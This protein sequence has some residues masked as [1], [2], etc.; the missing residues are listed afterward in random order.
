MKS[1][2]SP[3]GLSFEDGLE[4][5]QVVLIEVC[6]RNE[7][8]NSNSEAVI[9]LEFRSVGQSENISRWKYSHKVDDI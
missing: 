6:V 3:S 9:C 8:Q 2:S 4:M 7:Q 1:S 5:D